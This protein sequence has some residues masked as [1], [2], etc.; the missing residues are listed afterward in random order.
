[1]NHKITDAVKTFWRA[2]VIFKFSFFVMAASYVLKNVSNMAKEAKIIQPS[3][4]FRVG[5][6]SKNKH[7]A[8]SITFRAANLYA[9][10]QRFRTD[11][12]PVKNMQINL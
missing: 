6:A 2:F 11:A 5:V 12:F 10:V 3:R 9:C 4:P 7:F 8:S 1:M